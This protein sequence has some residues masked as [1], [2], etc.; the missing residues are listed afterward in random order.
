MRPIVLLAV[1]GL[2]VSVAA[3]SSGGG[4]VDAASRPYVDALARDMQQGENEV[5][6][7]SK[8]A[9]C[10]APRP[11]AAVGGGDRLKRAGVSPKEFVEADSMQDLRGLTVPAGAV[12]GVERALADCLDMKALMHKAFAASQGSAC[13]VAHA[14]AREF[15]HVA[16]VGLVDGS[17]AG[18]RASAAFGRSVVRTAD[19]NCL[20]SLV[21][22]QAGQEGRISKT[23]AD[24]MARA[25]DDEIARRIVTA[26]MESREPAADDK[27]AVEGAA[28]ACQGK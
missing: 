17:E 5:K 2:A 21:F 11:V 25:L 1:A 15:A 20:E 27:S 16:A 4:K 3:C 6:A 9:E 28:T 24:C 13:L 12:R 7:T 10:F 18:N 14:D 26:A 8:E 23:M 22:G 19:A